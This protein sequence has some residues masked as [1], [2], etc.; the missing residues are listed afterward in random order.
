MIVAEKDFAFGYFK[1]A[2]MKQNNKNQIIYDTAISLLT[3]MREQVQDVSMGDLVDLDGYF[4]PTSPRTLNEVLEQFAASAQNAQGFPKV[5]KLDSESRKEELR[6]AFHGYDVTWVAKEM[7]SDPMGSSLWRRYSPEAQT[8]NPRQNTWVKWVRA[9]KES[10]E[11]LIRYRDVSAFLSVVESNLGDAESQANLAFNIARNVKGL[12]FALACD[13][14]KELGFTSYA[15]PDVHITVIFR[16]LGLLPELVSEV[17]HW[18]KAPDWCN[19]QIFKQ[20]IDFASSCHEYGD[21]TAPVTPYKVDKV[22]WLVS[23]G[24]FYREKRELGTRRTKFI[25]RA[26]EQL[27]VYRVAEA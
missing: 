6:E 5:I 8:H 25:Q 10:A 9:I 17:R 27:E 11:Y 21:E 26:K 16:E 12:G 15:K 20:V 2:I 24:S 18:Y 23:T 7:D 22:M 4:N 1:D 14:L 19:Y 3:E 13:A